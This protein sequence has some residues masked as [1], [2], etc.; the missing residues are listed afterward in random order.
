NSVAEAGNYSFSILVSDGSKN[1][2]IIDAINKKV[3]LHDW[4]LSQANDSITWSLPTQAQ[5]RLSDS[6]VD[7]ALKI[8]EGRINKFGVTEPTLQRIGGNSHEI[9]LQMPGVED[10][11]RVKN[12]IGSESRLEFMKVAENTHTAGYRT[13]G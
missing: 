12:L 9:L 1:Q 11:E 2:E 7:Q 5:A 4:N 3:D 13:E 8:I 10:P 6:A